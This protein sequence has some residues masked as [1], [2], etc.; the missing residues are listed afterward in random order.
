[1]YVT[2]GYPASIQHTR[3]VSGIPSHSFRTGQASIIRASGDQNAGRC[4]EKQ[5]V[6]LRIFL[7]PSIEKLEHHS[8]MRH[9]FFHL[10]REFRH[11]PPEQILKLLQIL[12]KNDK[13]ACLLIFCRRCIPSG[14]QNPLKTFFLQ[15]SVLKIPYTSSELYCM[16]KILRLHFKS[17]RIIF[18]HIIHIILRNTHSFPG[19]DRHTVAALNTFPGPDRFSRLNPDSGCRTVLRAETAADTLLFINYNHSIFL[20]YLNTEIIPAPVHFF[21]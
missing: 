1:M 20:L 21:K 5:P 18:F 6:I 19:T 13:M 10:I 9:L 17:F 16:E 15:F 7:S 2:A 12:L 11:L 4:I 3:G 14:L 8:I